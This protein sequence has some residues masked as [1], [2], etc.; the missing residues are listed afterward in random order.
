MVWMKCTAS[1]TLNQ[2]IIFKLFHKTCVPMWPINHISLTLKNTISAWS[3]LLSYID[4]MLSVYY[5][6]CYEISI[7]RHLIEFCSIFN[8]IKRTAFASLNIHKLYLDIWESICR[9]SKLGS[10]NACQSHFC[11]APCRKSHF[12]VSQMSFHAHRFPSIWPLDCF[13]RSSLQYWC[14]TTIQFTPPT[15]LICLFF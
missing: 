5:T 13:N 4:D 8:V 6:I 10:K 7:I 3:L 2:W 12:T 15:L 14:V 11:I 1:L 9:Y